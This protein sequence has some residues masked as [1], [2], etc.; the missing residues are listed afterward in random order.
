MEQAIYL[1]KSH[2][3]AT[4]LQYQMLKGLFVLEALDQ[5]EALMRNQQQL[6]ASVVTVLVAAPKEPVPQKTDFGQKYI[7]IGSNK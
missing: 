4:N 7:K 6:A 5:H 3:Y 1:D 2:R